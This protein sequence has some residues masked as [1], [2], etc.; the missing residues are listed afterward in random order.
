ME[1]RGKRQDIP[2]RISGLAELADNFWWSWHNEAR[3]L[4]K[5]LSRSAWKLSI[6]NPVKMLSNMDK[7]VIKKSQ[8][9]PKFLKQYDIVMDKFKHDIEKEDSWFS[10]NITNSKSSM[11]AFFS[12]EYGFH[13]SLP[14]YAGGLGFLAGDI[15]KESSDLGIPIV[16]LGFMYPKGYLKQRIALDGWQMDQ[17]EILDRENIPITRLLNENK[18]HLI[19]K[20]P[21]IDP[22]IFIE[23]WKVHIGRASLYLLDTDININ[24]PWNRSITSHLYG[25]A[26][27]Q[28]LRQEIILGIGGTEVLNILG[29]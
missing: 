14:F 8:K 10:D 16:G 19:V 27:E 22:P 6:H 1:D 13:H 7:T 26:P 20:V 3:I 21:V 25:V 17:D 5:M 9:D 15:L 12:A 24:D 2:E 18:E 23:I 28:R 29:L 4:L 11:I